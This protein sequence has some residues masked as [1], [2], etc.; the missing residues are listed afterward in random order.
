M[1][2]EQP[3]GVAAE[4]AL[5]QRISRNLLL[6][7]A[8]KEDFEPGGGEPIAEPGGGLEE[9]DDRIELAIGVTAAGPD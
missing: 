7:Q 3:D 9:R 2:G 5:A 4:A 8:I 6:H 1:G